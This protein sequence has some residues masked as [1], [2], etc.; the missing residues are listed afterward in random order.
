VRGTDSVFC[1]RILAQLSGVTLE[2]KEVFLVQRF[3]PG[4]ADIINGS[5][6]PI[7][8]NRSWVPDD[9]PRHPHGSNSK[10]AELND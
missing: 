1:V 7:A 6:M 4:H 8:S 3:N 9:D 5:E 2:R 10:K